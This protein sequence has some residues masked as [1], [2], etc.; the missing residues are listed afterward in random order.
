MQWVSRRR[1]MLPTAPGTLRSSSRLTTGWTL[2]PAFWTRMLQNWQVPSSPSSMAYSGQHLRCIS[3]PCLKLE[4]ICHLQFPQPT[5]LI[6]CRYPHEFAL[7]C[8]QVVLLHK[9]KDLLISACAEL[10][11]ENVRVDVHTAEIALSI[12]HRLMLSCRHGLFIKALLLP[13]GGES[14]RRK[15]PLCYCPEFVRATAACCMSIA[16]KFCQT[17]DEPLGDLWTWVCSSNSLSNENL[18]LCWAQFRV[19]K[20]EYQ[21]HATMLLLV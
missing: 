16:L 20:V 6:S 2:Q 19:R 21:L 4:C 7:H 14:Y 3:D 12:C 17:H 18:L 1:S 15:M 5:I 8:G 11:C 13:G 9:C 10:N